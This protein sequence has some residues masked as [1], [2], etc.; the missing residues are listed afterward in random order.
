MAT[1]RL[2]FPTCSLAIALL[3]SA[4]GGSG[5]STPPPTP[6]PPPPPMNAAPTAVIAASATSAPEG[7]VITLDGS[8]SSDP[9]GDTLTF[10][11]TQIGGTIAQI[12]PG[13][14][15][16]IIDV[17]LPDV[18][19]DQNLTF[20]LVVSDGQAS[21]DEDVDFIVTDV[22]P[23]I[24]D[25]TVIYN[26]V[27]YDS[28]PKL[29]WDGLV[30]LTNAAG[31]F[32]FQTLLE[33]DSP[34]PA[35]GLYAKSFPS[36]SI[37]ISSPYDRSSRRDVSFVV[38]PTDNEVEMF[39]ERRVVPLET[40]SVALDV[41]APCAVDAIDRYTF[42]EP[43]GVNGPDPEG[44]DGV[45]VGRSTGGLAF[46]ERD[47]TVT[48]ITFAPVGTAGTGTYCDIVATN[49]QIDSDFNR[50]FGLFI[51][52]RGAFI[53]GNKVI[54]VDRDAGTVSLFTTKKVTGE[55]DL[56][57]TVDE[58]VPIELDSNAPLEFVASTVLNGSVYGSRAQAG[59][60]LIYSDGEFEGTH[61]LVI[62]GMDENGEISQT[63]KSW[64]R[65]IPV[66]VTQA[67]MHEAQDFS[68]IRT[69]SLSAEIVVLTETLD[70]VVVF[71]PANFREPYIFDGQQ[72]FARLPY[73]DAET[74]LIR[75]PA[76]SIYSV[77]GETQ[78]LG[79]I[80]DGTNDVMF[81]TFPRSP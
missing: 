1:F 18:P 36:D 40:V 67:A 41:N 26:F 77:A 45:V 11:W 72:D 50:P 60:A 78:N 63:V 81:L 16:A 20:E 28:Q 37:F 23:T 51:T 47:E 39:V 76:A 8:A 13:A 34:Q 10:I 2:H 56:S 59:L 43:S 49:R 58:T 71:R 55:T 6:P 42:S 30:G 24:Q 22:P 75:D 64:E 19:G 53:G 32:V 61:R 65:G 9:D 29:I 73:E 69:E 54:A 46:F 27:S 70:T 80:R 31:E 14:S 3:L 66:D 21:D 68:S 62:I 57:V 25:D 33:A 7:S 15:S 35:T 74:F 38:K 17:T 12:S 48:D 44:I 5:S 79:I 4:C 52:A